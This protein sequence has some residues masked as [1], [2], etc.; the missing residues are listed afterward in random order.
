M[1]RMLL[2]THPQLDILREEESTSLNNSA[3]LTHL[4]G[5]ELKSLNRSRASS[6][7]IENAFAYLDH[8]HQ[9]FKQ[10][11]Q[12]HSSPPQQHPQP[13]QPQQQPQEPQQL[14]AVVKDRHRK[15]NVFST[16]FSNYKSKKMMKK[17]T[18]A[19]DNEQYPKIKSDLKSV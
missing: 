12:Q 9:R 1:T 19:S 6:D 3:E 8:N 7:V 17:K 2:Q 15:N 5:P 13:Q 11:Q 18:F 16:M 10:Q 14:L 4:F